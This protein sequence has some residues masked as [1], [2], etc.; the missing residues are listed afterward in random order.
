MFKAEVR[1][2]FKRGVLDPQGETVG[3]SL[4]SLGFEQVEDVRIGR[5]MEIRL[6]AD[7][8]EGAREAVDNMCRQLLAN[9]VLEEFRI[10]IETLKEVS[11]EEAE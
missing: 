5:L 7:D 2:T 3:R 1:V 9:P 8:E 11:G 4:R 10:E 6:S